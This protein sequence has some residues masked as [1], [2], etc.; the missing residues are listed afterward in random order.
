MIDIEEV[1]DEC[2]HK[3]DDGAFVVD[4]NCVITGQQ[5]DADDIDDDEK[6]NAFK[7]PVI[8]GTVHL[9]HKIEKD[10]EEEENIS[11]AA[12]DCT[13][14]SSMLTDIATPAAPAQLSNSSLGFAKH[15]EESIIKT[16][17]TPDVYEQTDED[18]DKE[19]AAAVFIKKCC[20]LLENGTMDTV[21]VAHKNDMKSDACSSHGLMAP[22]L[23]S[24]ESLA[25]E[26]LAFENND[27]NNEKGKD[28]STVKNKGNR[29]KEEEEHHIRRAP[30]KEWVGFKKSLEN[31]FRKRKMRETTMTDAGMLAPQV[32]LPISEP[33]HPLLDT[34]STSFSDISDKNFETSLDDTKR[35][36]A[37]PFKNSSASLSK[38]LR[39]KSVRAA[40]KVFNRERCA[41]LPSDTPKCLCPSNRHSNVT[42]QISTFINKTRAI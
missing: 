10:A 11:L 31:V 39:I 1:D 15:D 3:V 16:V 35:A 8:E 2:E 28:S 20:V 37:A 6:L 30:K 21:F 9:L 36:A 5:D 18:D 23:E 42:H 19:M 12:K 40:K 38:T 7:P 13:D 4:G 26:L 17:S 25:R 34:C 14:V 41:R 33:I 27:D 24:D 29:K 32:G 22:T